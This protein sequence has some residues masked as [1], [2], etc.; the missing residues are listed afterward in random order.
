[1]TKGGFP[2]GELI[3]ATQIFSARHMRSSVITYHYVI[4]FV[5]QIFFALQKSIND[6]SFF[7]DDFFRFKKQ[8]MT[9]LQ[10][11]IISKKAKV[12]CKSNVI[13]ADNL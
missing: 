8:P 5:C 3:R 4:S 10:N 2:R 7:S 9:E 6:S 13:M 1:M 11:H 12:K